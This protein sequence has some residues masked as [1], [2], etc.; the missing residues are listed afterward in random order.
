ME[1]IPPPEIGGGTWCLSLSI[2]LC[3]DC[4]R[5]SKNYIVH[6]RGLTIACFL[7]LIYDIFSV[8]THFAGLSSQAKRGRSS[9]FSI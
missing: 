2:F 4:F 8:N 1:G 7:N 6:C 3:M 5:P 9:I